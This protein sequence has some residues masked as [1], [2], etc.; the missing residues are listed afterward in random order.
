M[1]LE[2]VWTHCPAEDWTGLVMQESLRLYIC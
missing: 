2:E 1:L